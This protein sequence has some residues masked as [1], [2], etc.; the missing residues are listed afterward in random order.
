MKDAD[1]RA[2]IKG[3]LY[4][5]SIFFKT[6]DRLGLKANIPGYGPLDGEPI[7]D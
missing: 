1:S 5:D 2:M 7:N 4:T 6:I 3:T